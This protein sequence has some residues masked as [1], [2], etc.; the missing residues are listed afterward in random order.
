MCV[1]HGVQSQRRNGSLGG[2]QQDSPLLGRVCSAEQNKRVKKALRRGG[3]HVHEVLSDHAALLVREKKRIWR[4]GEF[5]LLPVC[6]YPVLY[7]PPPVLSFSNLLLSY[8]ILKKN[9]Y[10]VDHARPNTRRTQ[11]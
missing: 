11:P 6:L 8:P 2:C 4:Q 5:I 3:F 7:S 10:V 9:R 1:A